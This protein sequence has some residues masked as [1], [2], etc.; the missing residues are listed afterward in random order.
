ML[1]YKRNREITGKL[2]LS[3]LLFILEYLTSTLI[4]YL[5]YLALPQY[6]LIWGL[7]FIAVVLSPKSGDSPGLV[8]DRI[9]AN[10][11]GA[12]IGFVILAF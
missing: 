7:I 5:I 8:Y 10:F 4:F 11:I 9:I 6:K 1:I 3:I 12:A 2:D